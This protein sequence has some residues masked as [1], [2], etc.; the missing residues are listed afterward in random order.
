MT[1]ELGI[2]LG[3]VALLTGAVAVALNELICGGRR[4]C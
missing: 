1:Q 2:V 4:R 3:I